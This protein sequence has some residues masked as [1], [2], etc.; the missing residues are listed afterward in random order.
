MAS[1]GRMDPYDF[2]PTI[3]VVKDDPTRTFGETR[4]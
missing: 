3:Y 4:K 2:N 1:G